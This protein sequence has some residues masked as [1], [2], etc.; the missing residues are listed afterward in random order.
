MRR[1]LRIC[2]LASA[3]LLSGCTGVAAP[4][5]FLVQRTGSVPGARLT[6][7]VNEEGGVRCDKGNT[8]E[9]SDHQIIVAREIE[10][11]LEAP[12]SS[13]LSLEPAA[14]SVLSYFVRD[15]KGSVRFSDNSSGQPEVFHQL[16]AFVLEVSQ[17][18]CHLRI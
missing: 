9:L 18:L 8:L 16:A 7:L 4:D 11:H 3:A 12:S 6:L 2:S 5:L 15:E 14:G 1:A 17:G 10:E 13:H